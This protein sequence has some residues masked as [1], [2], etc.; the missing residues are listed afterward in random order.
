[1][2][3]RKL[4]V[5]QASSLI[6]LIIGIL[7][8]FLAIRHFN[9]Y[10]YLTPYLVKNYI[11]GYGLLSPVIY[12]LIY[13]L[14]AGFFFTGSILSISSGLAFG[15]VLGSVYTVIGTLISASLS[16][17]LARWIGRIFVEHA[18]R[19]GWHQIKKLDEDISN[20]G[21]LLILFLRIIP[22]F[23]FE[24]VNL[25]AGL[26]KIRFQD[27]FWGTLFGCIP[28]SLAYSY[29]GEDILTGIKDPIALISIFAVLF[30]LLTPVV[31]RLFY[32][33]V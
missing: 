21:F 11:L 13:G 22:L 2:K 16:F 14:T 20:R 19:T 8:I 18:G 17:F 25:A 4:Y 29:L 23:P 26:S 31:Y 28:G 12:I 33:K 5:T 6:L 27:Y 32:I 24:G 10:K 3:D 7:V 30:L 15:P 1:M 9:F